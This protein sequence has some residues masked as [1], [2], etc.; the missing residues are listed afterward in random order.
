MNGE[1]SERNANGLVCEFLQ[2]ERQRWVLRRLD[3]EK[4]IQT[5]DGQ[6]EGIKME[7]HSERV[8][9]RLLCV[10]STAYCPGS[11]SDIGMHFAPSNCC[12]IDSMSFSD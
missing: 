1:G 8:L 6:I 7:L 4:K 3:P 2:P 10:G 5:A 9:K 12:I 11:V